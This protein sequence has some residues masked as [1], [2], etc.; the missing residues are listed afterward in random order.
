[1]G[2]PN[3]KFEA[4]TI[5]TKNFFS[6]VIN[7][8]YGKIV[9]HHSHVA[10]KVKG[11]GHSFCNQ[12]VPENKNYFSLLAHN[13]FGFDFFFVVK[14]FRLCVWRTKNLS[15]GGTNLTN[16]NYAN[17]GE[18]VKFIDTIKFNQQSLEK[19]AESMTEEQEEKIRRSSQKFLTKHK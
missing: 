4:L 18:Q 5:V 19:L 7:L 13:L 6:N 17:I 1:M 10:G 16:V 3:N 2:F 15:I 12:K 11:F 14:G 9:L 8:M